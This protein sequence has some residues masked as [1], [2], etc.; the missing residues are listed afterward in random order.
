MASANLAY[1]GKLGFG[2][3]I[4]EWLAPGGQLRPLVEQIGHYDFLA[5]DLRATALARPGW[6]LYSLLCFDLW[7]KLFI[8]RSLSRTSL[9][10]TPMRSRT[11]GPQPVGLGVAQT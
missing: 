4:F 8:D 6:F 10:F 11:H 7:H 2:Q 9:P 1:R 3:P 5:P